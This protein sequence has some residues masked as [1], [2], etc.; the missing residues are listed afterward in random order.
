MMDDRPGKVE[1]VP[2]G[3]G[4]HV[5]ASVAIVALEYVPGG[6]GVHTLAPLSL[7]VPAG[8][9]V[10]LADPLTP[11]KLPAGHPTQAVARAGLYWPG[12]HCAHPASRL[13]AREAT[14]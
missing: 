7:H 5:A 10:H 13:V 8:Q 3:Q 9:A 14:P 12:T 2:G 11:V 6:Q 4:V 1:Y